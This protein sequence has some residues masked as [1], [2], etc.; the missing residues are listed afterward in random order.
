MSIKTSTE[1]TKRVTLSHKD[2]SNLGDLKA[3][4]VKHQTQPENYKD[5]VVIKPWGYEFLIFENEHV[6]VW[7]LYIKKDHSTSMHCHPSKRTS[8]IMLS[9]QALCNTFRHRYFLSG[10]EPLIIEAAVFHCTKALSLDGI[11]VIE[12]ETPPEKL[13]LVR[14]KDNY[15]RTDLSYEG[16]SQMVTEEL[17][18]Y[19]YF[20][21]DKE[22]YKQQKYTI[23]DLF[24]ISMQDFDKENLIL[25]SNTLY[26]VCKGS[27]SDN[28]DSI[29]VDTGEVESEKYLQQ[30][31]IKV[32]TKTTVM[33]INFLDKR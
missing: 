22:H 13:D 32:D 21:F 5:K 6:A 14:L 17:E 1:P 27:I 10:G 16:Q 11:Y 30:M 12:I 26:C 23:R 8:L 25:N 7:F 18:K 2:K 24:S 28:H 31:N 19:H 3:Q 33:N 29:I 20:Y 15:G 4:A 9:G